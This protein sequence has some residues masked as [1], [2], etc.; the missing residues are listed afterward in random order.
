[1]S[2]RGAWSKRM[3]KHQNRQREDVKMSGI[4]RQKQNVTRKSVKTVEPTNK[5]NPAL[6]IRPRH[7]VPPS[8]RSPRS[9]HPNA[10]VHKWGKSPWSSRSS[11]HHTHTSTSL[12]LECQ[13]PK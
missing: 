1:M 10:Y 3:T 2:D 8:E 11:K 9:K 13:R 4:E 12:E 7:S 5:R 6:Y